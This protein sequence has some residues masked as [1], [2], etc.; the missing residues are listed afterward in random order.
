[1][2]LLALGLWALQQDD[3]DGAIAAFGILFILFILIFAVGLYAYVA[4]CLMKIADKLG[5]ADSW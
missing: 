3:G 1:M 2:N 5:V 4:F